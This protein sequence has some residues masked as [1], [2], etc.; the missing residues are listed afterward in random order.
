MSLST[1]NTVHRSKTD[2][3]FLFF[4]PCLLLL[5][6]RIVLYSLIQHGNIIRKSFNTE[7]LK[8]EQESQCDLS[9]FLLEWSFLDRQIPSCDWALKLLKSEH[10]NEINMLLV[11]DVWKPETYCNWL[12]HVELPLTLHI[13][14]RLM[15]HHLKP[16]A[17]SEQPLKS[18]YYDLGIWWNI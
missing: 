3:F 1:H 6:F 16:I 9:A 4:S 13:H 5:C 18:S 7:M 8:S 14:L 2:L 11:T 17:I 15:K 10:F 12:R